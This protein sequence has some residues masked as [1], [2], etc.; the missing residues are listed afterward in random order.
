MKALLSVCIHTCGQVMGVC[1]LCVWVCVCVCVCARAHV[2]I[3]KV[4]SA[5]PLAGPTNGSSSKEARKEKSPKSSRPLDLSSPNK[6][7]P[8]PLLHLQSSD[9]PRLPPGS[10]GFSS[11]KGRKNQLC[12]QDT[13]TLVGGPLC[14]P[15]CLV[16]RSLL[17]SS[18]ALWE[19]WMLRKQRRRWEKMLRKQKR[20][21]EQHSTG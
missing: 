7:Q 3:V 11:L 12:P 14:G 19:V 18:G 4:C 5:L 15:L 1:S 6:H 9:G 10:W 16:I 21:Q 8:S 20:G 13:H 2:P 17:C